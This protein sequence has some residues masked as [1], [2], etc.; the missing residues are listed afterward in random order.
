MKNIE[1]YY[2]KKI[3]V[4]GL[5]KSGVSA[6]GLLHKLGAFVTVNDRQPFSENPEAQGL[7]EQGIKVICGSHPIELL[8]EGFELIVKNPGIPYN[9]PM[10]E[11][12]RK[13]NI[14]VIT[15]VELAY[16]ISEAPIIGITGTNGKTTTT[17]IIHHMINQQ[18]KGT[19]LLA[20]NIG[21]PASAVAEEATS[22]QY[23]TMELSSFQLM[24]IESFHP[25]I[26]VITNIYEAHLDYHK[27]RDEY[28][29]AKWNIQKNQTAD[30][31]L[32]INWDQGELQNLTK[33]TK[34]TVIPFSTTQRLEKGAYVKNGQLMFNDEVIGER[35][36]IL[37]PGDHNLENILASIAVAKTIGISSE[38]I[39]QVL[40]T[41]KGVPHRTQ[42]VTELSGRK[43]YNDSKATNI[44]ATQSALKGFKQ[45]VILLAGGLDRGTEFDELRPFLKNV[46]ELIVFGETAEKIARIGK[47][48]G[49]SVQFVENV[50]KAVPVAFKASASG[51]VILLSPACASWD[52]YRTF[53]VRGNAYMEA[54]ETLAKEVEQ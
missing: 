11:K 26:S 30:D 33:G 22:E 13:L 10:I 24:G 2:H 34:A 31:F 40:E 1:N 25:Q 44:L 7:L 19:S 50:E 54:I 5:A 36:D 49:V 53:E 29:M 51:D 52:Q 20:G 48:A 35:D 17:T 28:V 3:L 8:D 43:F 45:P 23:I 46:K 15:E 47:E 42:F 21:F 6:A 9:N 27:T 12:A 41:F 16:Q 14:P 4:L 18:K 39:M 32:V 37:L 38:A